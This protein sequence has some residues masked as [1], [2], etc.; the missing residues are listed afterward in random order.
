MYLRTDVLLQLFVTHGIADANGRVCQYTH[1]YIHELYTYLYI[2]IYAGLS[3]RKSTL[4]SMEG[5]PNYGP[6]WSPVC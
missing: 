2:E 1:M 5:C 6:F 3:A 4:A